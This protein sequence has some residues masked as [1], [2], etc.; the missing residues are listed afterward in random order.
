MQSI[1]DN[2]TRIGCPVKL[3]EHVDAIHEG[4]PLGYVTM[5][6]I[7]ESKFETSPIIEALLVYESRT[8]CH[9]QKFLPPSTHY[10]Q[11]PSN[12]A[13]SKLF[14]YGNSFKAC[15]NHGGRHIRGRGSG[16]MQ[17]FCQICLKYGHTANV[18]LYRGASTFQPP[19]SLGLYAQP[20]I[21]LCPFPS[22]NLVSQSP[23]LGLIHPQNP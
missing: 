15:S 3:D 17:I 9:Q 12:F 10:S 22:L 2:V 13:S 16:V 23:M 19:N 20:P 21:S 11:P 4:L 5:I 7:F 14:G 18:C 8:T 6:S 1:V